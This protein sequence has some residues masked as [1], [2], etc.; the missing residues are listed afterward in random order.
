MLRELLSKEDCSKCRL[1]CQFQEDELMDAPTFTE[2][3]KKYVI[4]N[5]DSKINFIKKGEIYQIELNR[6]KNNIYKCPLLTPHGCILENKPFDCESWP[7]YVMKKDDDYVITLSNDCPI[8][9]KM[10]E[11][12]LKL[13]IDNKFK[14]I[15]I[16]IIKKY[17]DMITNYN[18][19][20]K[21]LYTINKKEL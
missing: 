19:E 8:M 14:D 20:L 9:S 11:E 10:D 3:E 5:I 4:E 13:F 2:D 7:Y 12:K 18:R 1:C 6:E 17:P 21:I 15:A 16:E